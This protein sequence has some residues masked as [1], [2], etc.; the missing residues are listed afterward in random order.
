MILGMIDD[1]WHIGDTDDHRRMTTSKIEWKCST[2]QHS[3]GRL[4]P[5]WQRPRRFG[6][7]CG[8]LNFDAVEIVNRLIG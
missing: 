3:L 5:H 1:H 2:R 8:Y 7:R 4:Q 6:K